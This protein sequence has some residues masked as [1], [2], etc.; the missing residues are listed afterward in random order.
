M[1][2]SGMR[3]PSEHYLQDTVFGDFSPL[4]GS[5]LVLSQVEG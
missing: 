5:K 3:N 2:R 4:R 1:E